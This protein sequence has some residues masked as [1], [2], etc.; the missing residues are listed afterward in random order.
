MGIAS[1]LGKYSSPHYA[2]AALYVCGCHFED[3]WVL[4]QWGCD[5]DRVQYDETNM[6]RPI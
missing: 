6:M 2:L 3:D 4:G 1:R 5:P